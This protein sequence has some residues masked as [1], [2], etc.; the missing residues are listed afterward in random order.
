MFLQY[1]E[2]ELSYLK[3]KDKRLGEA[4]D[5]IGFIQRKTD[6]DLFSS[7]VHHIVGQQISTAAQA[8][9]WRRMNDAFGEITPAVISS[10]SAE[11]L[12]AHGITFKKAYYIK[13]FTRKVHEGEF[14]I[15]SLAAKSDEEVIAELSGLNG[16][17]VWTAEMIMTFCM[18]RPNILSYGD[19]AIHRGLRMLYHHRSID[20][21]LFEKYRRRFSPYC[22]VASL[23]L[24]AIA[25][26]AIDGMQDY[27]PKKKTPKKSIVKKPGRGKTAGETSGKAGNETGGKA[28]SETDVGKRGRK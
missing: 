25:G 27:A 10:A 24:W 28:G 22:T 2:K 21:K 26:G 4:I 7:V 14:D 8:T 20:R 16:I 15:H 9:I 6:G 12:Q 13:D 1:G 23:Y 3:Q 17:G 11:E 5:A 18:E 19:L